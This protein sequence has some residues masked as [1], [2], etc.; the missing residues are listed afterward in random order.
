MVTTNDLTAGYP[1]PVYSPLDVTMDNARRVGGWLGER[2]GPQPVY[3]AC[4]G[5]SGIVIAS[6]VSEYLDCE[7]LY[8][9]KDKDNA[10][11]TSSV[12]TGARRPVIIVDDC[13]ASG[14]TLFKLFTYLRR[15]DLDGCVEVIHVC[16]YDRPSVFEKFINLK[17]HLK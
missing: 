3:L 9:R 4:T 17:F 11:C 14:A 16:S 13:V 12:P 10:H 8:L 6:L 15:Y 7:I 5:T 1:Y 2:Y